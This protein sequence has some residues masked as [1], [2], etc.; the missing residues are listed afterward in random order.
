[1]HGWMVNDFGSEGGRV[2]RERCEQRREIV[3]SVE[4]R[5]GVSRNSA[6]A[7]PSR[8]PK[9]TFCVI[10]ANDPVMKYCA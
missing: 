10:A 2:A 6:P 4:V 8:W 1:M 3:T 7:K 9:L 5:C